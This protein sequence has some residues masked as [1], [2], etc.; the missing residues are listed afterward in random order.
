[1]KQLENYETST[2]VQF[3]H[4]KKLIQY[5]VTGKE[6][7]DKNNQP[8][9]RLKPIK[10]QANATFLVEFLWNILPDVVHHRNMLKLYRNTKGLFLN[11]MHAVYIDIDFSE[12]LQVGIKYK[13][14]S[15]HWAK[16][17]VTVHSGL[18]QYLQEKTYHPY[19]SDDRI[20]DQ[21]SLKF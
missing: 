3:T 5:D 20:H 2:T 6:I 15:L 9:K 19:I 16:L 7:L 12:N 17:M 8:V 18:I 13:P 1:M 11:E 21:V 10:E 14:M 4:F